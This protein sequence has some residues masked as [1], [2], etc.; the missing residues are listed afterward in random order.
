MFDLFRSR[1]KAVR[2]LLGAML[3]MVALSMLLYLIPG[4]GMSTSS[5][6]GDDDQIVAEI[7]KTA[8]SVAE[9]DQQMRNAMQNRQITP[10]LASSYLPQLIDQAISDRA[11]AYEAQQLGFQVSDQDLANT[12]RGFQFG[13]LPPAQ[14]RDYIEGQLGM[15]VAAFENNIRLNAYENALQEVVLE[16]IVATPSEVEAIFKRHNQKIKL[17]YVAFDPTKISTELKPTTEQL[18]AYYSANRGFFVMPE[19]KSYQLIVADQAKVAETIQ[20]T[21]SQVESY[22]NSHKDQ[23]RTP[24]R[25]HARHVLL[26]TTGKSDADK[27]KIKAKADDL[28]KQLKSGADFAKLAT[29]N[30]EDPGSASKGGDLGW[31]VRG[32]MV[33]EFED[34]T[35]SLQPNQISDVITT[36]YGYHIIQVLEK[37]Q[38]R[39]R[40]LAEV[41]PEIVGTLRNQQVFERMQSL[42]DQAHAE[43]A[44]APQSADQIASKLGLQFVTV[45]RYKAGDPIPALG[46]DASLIS[47]LPAMKKGE[48]TQILQS[49]NKLVV[50]VLTNT[51]PSHPAEFDEMEPQIRTRYTQQEAVRVTAERAKKTADA[52]EAS[53]GDLRAAAKKLGYEV[54]TTD[55]FARDAA[56]EGIGTAQYLGASFDKPVGSILGVIQAG[57]QTVVPKII[58]RQAAD[59]SQLAAQRDNIVMQV[60]QQKAVER[61][62]LLRDSVVSRLIQQGKIKKHQTVIN[63][64]VAR[65]R[66]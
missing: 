49:G 6:G 19:T 35:F 43:L 14:Y 60:K 44:K 47:S 57:A 26:A 54:K 62:G 3:V 28:L 66:A 53:G 51:F 7:G 25:V 65:Y 37:E 48:V 17:E 40:N 23:Y 42:T 32:Q 10:E 45:E 24:E 29:A 61:E 22:Y 2:L 33:K 59:M 1:A 55:F 16:G 18:K 34:T 4:A 38:P 5:G 13:S 30:S 56:A 36:Q 63:R 41:K 52:A 20:V 31:V 50:G 46:T 11:L 9:I 8:V 15:T 39:L 58:D 27:A 12:I 21:D 64:I